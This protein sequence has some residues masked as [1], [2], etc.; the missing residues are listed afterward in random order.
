MKPPGSL[1]L[2]PRSVSY[3]AEALRVGTIRGAADSLG[4]EPSV[5]SRKIRQLEAELGVVLLER[6][7]TGIRPTEAALLVLEHAKEVKASAD[8]LSAR[9]EELQGVQ[10]GN[11]HVVAGEGFF[12]DLVTIALTRFSDLYPNIQV[13]LSLTSSA[14]AMRLVCEDVAQ[15]GLALNVAP[16]ENIAIKA[17]GCRPICLVL[18]PGH[19][20]LDRRGAVTLKD[21]LAYPIALMAHGFGLRQIVQLAAFTERISIEPKFVTN[22][23][24]GLKQLASAR[25]ALTFMSQRAVIDEVESGRLT[26]LPIDNPVFAAAETQLFVKAARPLSPAAGKLLD[27][28]DSRLFR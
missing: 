23:M 16:S 26:T 24:A 6:T 7:T 21:V 25:L 4:I 19:P 8:V 27:V 15:I 12:D 20:L 28:I 13:S 14:D 3:F 22:T 10:R 2:S 9:L 17:C 18:W 1:P 5:L 11:V